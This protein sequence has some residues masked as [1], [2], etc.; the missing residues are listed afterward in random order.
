[1][2]TEQ[3]NIV[4]TIY[5]ELRSISSPYSQCNYSNDHDN[6]IIQALAKYLC[7]KFYM[8]FACISLVHFIYYAHQ[9]IK[10][11]SRMNAHEHR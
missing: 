1:M 9:C 10:H 2:N 8:R 3:H 6:V 4:S 5:Y 11:F 7:R